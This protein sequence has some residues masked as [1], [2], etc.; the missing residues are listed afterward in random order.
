MTT[1]SARQLTTESAIICSMAGFAS[2]RNFMRPCGFE[3]VDDGIWVV[4]DPPSTSKLPGRTTEFVT[5][6]VGADRVFE[7]AHGR[8]YSKYFICAFVE[9]DQEASATIVEYKAAGCRL[10]RREPFF[11]VNTYEAIDYPSDNVRRVTTQDAAEA[12]GKAARAKQILHEH[13]SEDDSLC[14]LYAAYA[15]P[16]ENGSDGTP[17]GWVRSI[18]TSPTTAYVAGLFVSEQHR[19]KGL[20]RALMSAMLKDDRRLGI[21]WSVLLASSA[22]AQLY[23]HLGYKVRGKLILFS[24]PK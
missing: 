24:A 10:M 20:G 23:P 9:N 3:A 15:E 12:V 11:V 13:V 1:T 14:R 8:S 22:G 16:Y 4:A 18:K 6:R 19:R 2:V 7:A 5:Y 21:E 17:I